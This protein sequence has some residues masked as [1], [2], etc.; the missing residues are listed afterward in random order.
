MMGQD[1][2]G[3]SRPLDP[4][5][6]PDS[7]ERGGGAERVGG[8]ARGRGPWSPS[9]GDVDDVDDV[10]AVAAVLA[11]VTNVSY[12][13][14]ITRASARS[15]GARRDVGN[16]HKVVGGGGGGGGGARRRRRRGGIPLG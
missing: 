10:A 13:N 4:L 8:A 3:R 2:L 11:D 16:S 12:I 5:W 15:G 9:G 6:I 7:Y 1:R 14:D